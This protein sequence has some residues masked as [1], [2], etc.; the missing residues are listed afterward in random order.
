MGV[1]AL[2][3]RNNLRSEADVLQSWPYAGRLQPSN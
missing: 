1:F 2:T 3:S